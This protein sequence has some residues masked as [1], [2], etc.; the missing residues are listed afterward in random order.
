VLMWATAI[1]DDSEQA[2][3]SSG[4]APDVAFPLIMVVSATSNPLG[5]PPLRVCCG[6]LSAGGVR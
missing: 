3:S 4:Q 6:K 1:I 2:D 5:E